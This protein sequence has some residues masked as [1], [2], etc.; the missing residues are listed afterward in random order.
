[1]ISYNK[2]QHESIKN[3]TKTLVVDGNTMVRQLLT[4]TFSSGNPQ[5]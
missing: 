4:R 5:Q 3:K 2:G 1:M